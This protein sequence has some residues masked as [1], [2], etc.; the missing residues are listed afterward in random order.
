MKAV[1]KLDVPEWQI[2][3]QVVI[4]FPDTMM[5]KAIC[6]ADEEEEQNNG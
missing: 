2:G 6:E 4:Y 5:K 3:K 1:I